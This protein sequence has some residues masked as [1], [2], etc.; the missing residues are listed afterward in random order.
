MARHSHPPHNHLRESIAQLAARL[1]AE[2]IGDFT[3]AKRKAAR[4]LGVSEAKHWPNNSEVEQ[5]LRAYQALFGPAL[6]AGASQHAVLSRL[7]A[8]ALE[9]MRELARFDPLLTGPVLRGTATPYSDIELMLFADSQKDVELHLL[10]RGMAYKTGEK[11]FRFGDSWRMAPLL[12][13]S[14]SGAAEVRLA[15][16][17]VDDRK[18]LPLCPVDGRGTQGARLTEVQS[19]LENKAP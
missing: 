14:D 19:L 6:G 5:A 11:R 8:Q 9:V 15:I 2:G 12:L 17:S 3:L 16:F 13:L 18:C 4:Q 7:R 10:N 1:M